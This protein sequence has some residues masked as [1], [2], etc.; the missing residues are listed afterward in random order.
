MTTLNGNNIRFLIF[1][2]LT[3]CAPTSLAEL[4]SEGEAQTRKLVQELRAVES[5]E[6][7]QEAIPRLKKQFNKLADLAVESRSFTHPGSPSGSSERG[8]PLHFVRRGEAAY[9]RRGGTDASPSVGREESEPSMASEELFAE[10]A[11]LYEMPGGREL[12]EM[13]QRDAIHRLR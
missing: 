3:S 12:I 1:L 11:R 2:F 8:L 10:L 4:R 13:A 9:G 7:L 6:D 5:K